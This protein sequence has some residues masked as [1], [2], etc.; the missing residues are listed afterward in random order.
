MTMI[1]IS[2]YI[3]NTRVLGP[4]IRSALWVH[5]CNRSCKGCIAQKMNTQVPNK[6]AIE[7]LAKVFLEIEYAE[8]ITISG[9][10]PFLQAKELYELIRLIRSQR[11]YGVIV[12]TGNTYEEL[13][14]S[15]DSGVNKLLSQTDILIDGRYIEELDDGLPYRGSS[16]QRI[17]MISDRYKD[18]YEDYYLKG[19]KRNIEI[20]VTEKNVYLTGVP[21]KNGLEVWQKFK[22]KAGGDNDTV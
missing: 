4:F 3:E 8:G 18:C 9:G 16:N 14:E 6:Y 12:Y 10:E 20:K 11:D 7:E 19:T 21:S 17:I 5:G 13:L 2:H 1:K 15:N 22:K